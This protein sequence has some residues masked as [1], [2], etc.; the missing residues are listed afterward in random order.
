MPFI[1][2]VLIP[3]IPSPAHLPT[4]PT[5][6][7]SLISHPLGSTSPLPSTLGWGLMSKGLHTVHGH[8]ARIISLHSMN[9]S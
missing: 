9:T 8:V 3:Y 4:S 6:A 7:L 5:Q 2:R 1:P